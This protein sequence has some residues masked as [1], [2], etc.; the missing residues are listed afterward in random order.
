MKENQDQIQS[1][2]THQRSN[3]TSAKFVRML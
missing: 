3:S 2:K 1:A